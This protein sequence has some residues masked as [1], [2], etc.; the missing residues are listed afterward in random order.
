MA[1]TSGV[2]DYL[3]YSGYD[4]SGDVGSITRIG[5]PRASLPATGINS[6]GGKERI[7]G[8]SDG[9]IAFHSY[10]NDADDQEHEVLKAFAT[11]EYVMYCRGATLGNPCAMLVALQMNYDWNRGTDG[12]LLATIQALGKGTDAPLEWGTQITAGKIT[13]SSAASSTGEVTAVSTAGAAMMLEIF[14]L[15]SGTPTV[16]LEDSSDTTTG[17]DGTWATLKTFTIQTAQTA[18]RLAV[19]GTV[20]KGVRATTTGTFSNLVFAIGM[21]RGTAS[22]SE[23]YT[24]SQA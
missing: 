8:L 23:A 19:A 21:R 1:K 11:T 3:F 16:L 15:A 24:G 9:E 13:H 20:N 4:I 5:A 6:A 2:P 18:E 12:S 7:Q 22:D 17:A 10:F 14:S